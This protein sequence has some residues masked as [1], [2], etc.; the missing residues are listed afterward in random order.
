MCI[1]INNLKMNKKIDITLMCFKK[2]EKLII[3]IGYIHDHINMAVC[4]WYL[5]KVTCPVNATMHAHRRREE[6]RLLRNK[7][8][9]QNILPKSFQFFYL[10]DFI[11]Y[12]NICTVYI[13]AD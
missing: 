10:K 3:E 7:D 11:F 2:N 4:I 8:D 12:T 6:K 9:I 5:V 1:V 13:L